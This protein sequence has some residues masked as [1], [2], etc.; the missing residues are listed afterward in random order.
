[1]TMPES[2]FGRLRQV[3]LIRYPAYKFK[4]MKEAI[5]KEY[6]DKTVSA[7]AVNQDV[8]GSQ[9]KT[10][11][12]TSR[13]NVEVIQSE[14]EFE[15]TSKHLCQ[16][17]EDTISN[18]I[19]TKNLATIAF[20]LEGSDYFH[21]DNETIDGEKVARVL[22]EWDNEEINFP[23]SQQNLKLWKTYLQTGEHKLNR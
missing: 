20:A 10:G 18:K 6:F 12:D 4:K 13:L 16:L 5:L 11:F 19:S 15:I 3:Y 22:F 9:V 23:I 2:P 8:T 14:E 7:E 21:W 17:V 1:M